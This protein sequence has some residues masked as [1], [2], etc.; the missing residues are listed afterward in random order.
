MKQMTIEQEILLVE[1]IQAGDKDA[2]RLFINQYQKLVFHIVYKTCPNHKDLED[3]CQDIFIKIYRNINGFR[4][5]CKVSTWIAK[6]SYNTCLNYLKKKKLDLYDDISPDYAH[7]DDLSGQG[8]LPDQDLEQQDI[9]ELLAKA[10]GRLPGR[11]QTILQL[12]HVDEMQYSE[13]SNIM[14]LPVGTVKSYL[15]RAR[16]LLKNEL[17]K[18][19]HK[20]EIWQ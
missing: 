12:Y 18:V 9:S 2:F 7:L 17:L 8:S 4:N 5:D 16:N 1:Q 15:F 10:M 20:E 19:Y 14:D 13:I 3:L 11:Y 6:I